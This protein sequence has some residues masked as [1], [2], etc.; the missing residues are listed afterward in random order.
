MPSS[1][2]SSPSPAERSSSRRPPWWRLGSTGAVVL[3]LVALCGGCIIVDDGYDGPHY[4]YGPDYYDDPVYVTI[5]ANEVMNTALG[6]GVGLFVEYES[7]GTWRLWT[8]CDTNLTGYACAFDVYAIAGSS[9]HNVIT[10]DLEAYDHVDITSSD[11]LVF[12]AETG[13]NFDGVTFDT[14]A[15]VSLE[16]ELVL[17]GYVEPSFIYWVGDGVLHEGAAGS[18][19]VFSPNE[20]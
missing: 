16:V 14:Q 18:P 8:S 10:E 11:S 19:V 7:G 12:Y 2:P 20:P 4:Y 15:G 17:D 9:V 13:S 5:D 3:V 6:E 1:H